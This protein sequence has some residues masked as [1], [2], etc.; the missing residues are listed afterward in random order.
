M[1][2]VV[3][4]RYPTTLHFV[5]A[6]GVWGTNGDHSFKVVLESSSPDVVVADGV[7]TLEHFPEA[8]DFIFEAAVEVPCA[9]PMFLACYIEGQ[10]VARRALFFGEVAFKGRSSDDVAAE[11]ERQQRDWS[12][13]ELEARGGAEVVYF[14]VCQGCR[15]GRVPLDV[16]NR[17]TLFRSRGRVVT[18]AR[19]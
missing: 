3:A 5:V 10:R 18:V 4:E 2:T 8:Q 15:F 9:G 17:K 11:L 16:E 19:G 6:L 13:A 7:I 1:S 12:D 14:S